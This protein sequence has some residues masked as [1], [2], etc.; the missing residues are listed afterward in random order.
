[1]EKAWT[2]AWRDLPQDKIQAWIERIPIHI[3]EIIRLEGGNKYAEGRKAF[4]RDH[5]GTRIKG[6]LSKHT[7]LPAE[8]IDD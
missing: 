5:K 7:Y 6:K 2:K 4:K 8:K 3:K 1:M